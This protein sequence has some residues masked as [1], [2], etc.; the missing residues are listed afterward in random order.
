MC[1]A[2]TRCRT[3]RV[4]CAVVCVCTAND[5]GETSRI[6]YIALGGECKKVVRRTV[7]TMAEFAANPADHKTKV[8][9]W[10]KSLWPVG[11]CVQRSPPNQGK[12]C[13]AAQPAPAIAAS[14][15]PERAILSN[16]PHSLP[17]LDS[18]S[19]SRCVII[20]GIHT[21][22]KKVAGSECGCFGNLLV[23][24]WRPP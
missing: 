7:I 4:S 2:Q 18:E 21:I 15:T 13:D 5:S 16:T 8:Q 3:V 1:L 24:A 10:C 6:R 12:W 11:V 19:S 22:Q 14:S 17:E 20:S 23:L 9:S